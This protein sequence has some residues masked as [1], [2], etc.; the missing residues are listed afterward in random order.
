MRAADVDRQAV[1]DRLREALNEGRLN[2]HEYD[3]RLQQ[4]Y[5]ARTYGELDG[6]LDDLPS[7]A[8]EA[9]SQLAPR[10]TAA[11]P[12]VAAGDDSPRRWLAGMWGPWLAT[13][14]ICTGIWAAS[15][16]AAGGF[17]WNTFWP[18]WVIGP[19]GAVC[20]ARTLR[21]FIDPDHAE[22]QRRAYRE[23]R[24]DARRDAR[25]DRRDR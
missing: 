19:W 3:E 21:S 2:L 16:V 25:K 14:V 15:Q 7:V 22:D 11:D 9:K 13:S 4:A 17:Y 5:A 10:A 23:A 24:R 12:A 6:L 18:I 20:L 8:P 1:A